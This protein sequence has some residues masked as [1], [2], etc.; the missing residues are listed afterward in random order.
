MLKGINPIISPDLLKILAEMG[1]GDEIILADAHFPGHTFC[2]KNVLRGDGLQIPD[3]LEG[4][5][6]LFELDSY[7]D[8]LIMMA[9]VEGDHL[10]PQ[11]EA[12]YM[13]AIRKHAPDAPAVKRISRFEYYDRAEKAF[14]CVI[15]GT[16]AKY[17]NI[18][19][20][21]GVTRTA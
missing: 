15:T 9:A 4:I 14:A 21:K 10:D 1:H 8:P 7:A 6:P 12:D 5:I 17:G 11:V 13:A 3:L 20:K 18:I 19:L 16:T 2:P